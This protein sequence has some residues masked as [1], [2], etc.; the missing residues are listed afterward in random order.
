MTL[1][2]A[3]LAQKCATLRVLSSRLYIVIVLWLWVINQEKMGMIL[4]HTSDWSWDV[5]QLTVSILLALSWL[6]PISKRWLKVQGTTIFDRPWAPAQMRGVRLPF[7]GSSRNSMSG[8]HWLDGLVKHDP[9]VGFPIG[10]SHWASSRQHTH[11]K[12]LVTRCHWHCSWVMVRQRKT[13]EGSACR[14]SACGFLS[15]TGVWVSNQHLKL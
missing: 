15:R 13:K 14:Q 3:W 5:P 12:S 1:N 2:T 4:T 7:S 11:R 9:S 8:N 6:V 10:V